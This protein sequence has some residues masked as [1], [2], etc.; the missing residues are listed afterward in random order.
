M[1][2]RMGP[3]MLWW[4][5]LIQQRQP[6]GRVVCPRA[7]CCFRRIGSVGTSLRPFLSRSYVTHHD[8]ATRL[9]T[10]LVGRVTRLQVWLERV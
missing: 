9:A 2:G 7:L 3:P 1:D 8:L 10:S 4:K 6:L 5:I